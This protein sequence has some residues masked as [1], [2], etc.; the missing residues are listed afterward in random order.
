MNSRKR[1]IFIIVAMVVGLATLGAI[2]YLLMPNQG[3]DGSSD[4][5][6]SGGAGQPESGTLILKNMDEPTNDAD[7]IPLGTFMSTDQQDK[8]VGELQGILQIKKS[9]TLYEGTVV[10]KSVT[11]DYDTSDITF[12]V[13]IDNPAAKYTVTFN[14]LSDKLT[15][16]DEAGKKVN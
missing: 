13:K 4:L 15:I 3:T 12:L 11:V 5:P 10:S 7:K 1:N 9:R 8:I 16:K 6:V 2:I 14:T